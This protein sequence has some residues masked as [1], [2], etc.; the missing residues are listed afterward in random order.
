MANPNA[1][2]NSKWVSGVS[3]NPFGRPP[4]PLPSH[5]E[6]AR[7]HAEEAIDTFVRMMREADDWK[8]RGWAAAQILDRA[9]GKPL[10]QSEVT[11]NGDMSVVIKMLLGAQV[12]QQPAIDVTNT[13]EELP[14][15]SD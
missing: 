12:P 8:E 13:P 1:H 15:A 6:K 4:K 2:L 3:A 5:L 11:T 14:D 7:A 9:W 10:Q